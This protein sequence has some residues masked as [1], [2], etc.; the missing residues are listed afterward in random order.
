MMGTHGPR[1]AVVPTSLRCF[2]VNGRPIVCSRHIPTISR[3]FYHRDTENVTMPSLFSSESPHH[4]SSPFPGAPIVASFPHFHLAESK[5]VKDIKGMSPQA[6]HHQTF[7][8]LNP[9]GRHAAFLQPA[10][11]VGV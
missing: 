6:E 5:Y 10:K 2:T 4:R 3:H 11:S 1:V 9:V 8:D 7:L